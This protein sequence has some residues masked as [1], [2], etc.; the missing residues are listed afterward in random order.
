MSTNVRFGSTY[1]TAGSFPVLQSLKNCEVVRVIEL[2]F[3][4]QRSRKLTLP[5]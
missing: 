1:E 3:W 4:F 5:Q 2:Y